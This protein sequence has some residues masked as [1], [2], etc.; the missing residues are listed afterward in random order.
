MWNVL[1]FNPRVCRYLLSFL[2]ACAVQLGDDDSVYPSRY[3][4]NYDGSFEFNSTACRE[5]R[6]EIMDVKVL[7]M[8]V[9]LMWRISSFRITPLLFA[10]PIKVI[11]KQRPGMWM[12]KSPKSEQRLQILQKHPWYG[13]DSAVKFCLWSPEVT[14]MLYFRTTRQS[15]WQCRRNFL[16]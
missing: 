16:T 14:V 8:W 3:L 13:A 7:T 6:Q 2:V 1:H 11:L 5:L 15:I 12:Y 9:I 4:E 10:P